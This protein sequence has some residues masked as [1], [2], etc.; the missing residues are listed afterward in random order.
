MK[1][2]I[3][4]DFDRVIHKYSEGWKDGTIYDEPVEGAIEALK[5]LREHFEV[6]IFTVLSDRGV[7]RNLDIEEWLGKH[8]IYGIEVTN[9]K[10]NAI[11]YIDDKGI[12]FTDWRR[13]I[14]TMEEVLKWVR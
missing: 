1:P 10:R 9:T 3:L 4:V 14:Q 12:R 8:G 11:A 2:C 13:T 7:E 6:V 5:M